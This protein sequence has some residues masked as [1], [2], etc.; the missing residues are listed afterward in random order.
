MV[1][2]AVTSASLSSDGTREFGA[3]APTGETSA[4]ADPSPEG[5]LSEPKPL[6]EGEAA[7]DDAAADATTEIETDATRT[8]AGAVE[9]FVSYA[10]WV[11]ASPAAAEDPSQTSEALGGLL[12]PADAAMVEAI[13]RAGGLDY[14]PSLGAY[15]VVG[16]SGQAN[17]PDAVMLEVVAPMTVQAETVWSKI[18]GVMTW[19]GGQWLPTSMR[20]TEI[21]QP[22]TP[23]LPVGDMSEPDRDIVLDGLGWE[24]F[25][26][27]AATN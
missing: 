22:N 17:A 24:L 3:A 25:S 14:R 2:V 16:I 8:Q 4:S 11:I 19:Q 5:S 1:A 9:A 7:A 18:G 12:N 27:S 10:T 23:S 6:E 13:D 26:N 20:P 21:P 15:R